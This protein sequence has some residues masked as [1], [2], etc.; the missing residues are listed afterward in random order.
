MCYLMA[1]PDASDSVRGITQWWLPYEADET[2]VSGALDALHGRGW[3]SLTHGRFF[4]LN[5][6][7]RGEI[8]R[9]LDANQSDEL[10]G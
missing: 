8:R 5:S 7:A 1:H 3:L 10:R 2:A 6:A 9:W 4:G